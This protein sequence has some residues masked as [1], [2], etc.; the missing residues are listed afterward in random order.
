MQAKAWLAQAL[1]ESAWQQALQSPNQQVRPWFYADGYV[2][3][4][5]NWPSQQQ[6]LT[7]LAGAS[8]RNLAFAPGHFLPSGELGSSKGVLIA[9]HND[10]HFAFLKHVAVGEQ[11]SM[12]LQSGQ[13]EHYQVR[14]IDV[15]HQSEQGFLA[16]SGLYLLTCYPFDSLA[17]GTDFRLLVSA[18]KLSSTSTFSS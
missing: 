8:G 1:I 18:D 12:Q 4:H 17:S 5:I 3:A 10:T 11:F 14:S 13:I 16:Q 6:E 7:V 15:I 2:T 9:G